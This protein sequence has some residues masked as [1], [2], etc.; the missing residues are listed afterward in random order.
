LYIYLFE[1]S[2]DPIIKDTNHDKRVNI[3][4][5]GLEISSKEISRDFSSDHF[6]I[7]IF[8][9]YTHIDIGNINVKELKY[10]AIKYVEYF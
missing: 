9:F 5:Y 3:H 7:N 10:R 8:F 4:D 1:P 6:L 2:F